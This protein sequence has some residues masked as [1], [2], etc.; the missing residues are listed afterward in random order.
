MSRQI[1]ILEVTLRDGS[2]AINF[3]FTARDT[4]VIAGELE[5]AG[6]D[7]IEVGHG[8]G[9]HASSMG[10]GEAVATDEEY[11]EAAASSLSRAKFGMFC[12]PGIA[13]LEDIDMAASYG[14]GFIR[15]GTNVTQVENSAP[16]IERARKHGMFVCANFMKS[17]V[18]E[19]DAFAEEVKKSHGYGTE[20]IYLVDSA[21]G[22]L[23]DTVRA[24]FD[25]AKSACDID[26]A[27]HG[28]DNIGL[29]VANSLVAA[30]CGARFIDSSLQGL[31]RSAGNPPT[32]LVVAAL[33]KAGYSLN[34]DLLDVMK[35]GEQ[36]I[37]PLVRKS[38]VSSLD[39]TC[40]YAEFHSSYMGVIRSVSGKYGVDPRELIIEVC[41]VD[42]VNCP[43][44]LAVEAAQ[45]LQRND[46]EAPTAQFGLADFFGHE[47]N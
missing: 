17:Y 31:G 13:R 29:G 12:I 23:P 15:V 11:C 14:M 3:A 7:W 1:D 40:G 26:L 32:E 39:V 38:G 24:Y 42:K 9:L 45:R 25:A 35:V 5:R 43:E 22:M 36:Y 6:F 18:L 19:P 10:Y 44:E 47:Q 4:V 37:R 27:F 30:D 21:G 28:H 20:C 2:Y 16:Y 34:V 8:V 33:Q 46:R 41:K